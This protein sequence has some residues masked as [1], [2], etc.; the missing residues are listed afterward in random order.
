MEMESFIIWQ[1]H[2]EIMSRGKMGSLCAK[3]SQSRTP[4]RF[5][6]PLWTARLPVPPV[7]SA[8][9]L[10][11]PN[12]YLGGFQF[13]RKSTKWTW[14][15]QGVCQARPM[16]NQDPRFKNAC[17]ELGNQTSEDLFCFNIHSWDENGQNHTL[18]FLS[19]NVISY[20]SF[21]SYSWD[22]P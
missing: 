21:Q 19:Q 5:L 12:T 20:S 11:G 16:Q 17:I 15:L 8:H 18:G 2:V 9:P 7:T 4:A 22:T 10:L 14:H 3:L 6:T 13:Q 1:K